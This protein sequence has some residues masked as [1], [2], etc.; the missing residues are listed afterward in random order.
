MKYKKGKYRK[1]QA[2]RKKET[3]KKRYLVNGGILAGIFLAAVIVFSY[4]TNKENNNI[5]ADLGAA[6]R[7]QVSFSYNGYEINALPAYAK[8]MD[9]TAVRGT[10]T[11][12]ANGRLEMK[13]EPHNSKVVS[14]V[15]GVYTL[16]GEE[17]LWSNELK[18]PGESVSL[19]FDNMEILSEERVLKIVLGIK[20]DT[21]QE[22]MYLY[23]RIVDAAGMN[24]EECLSYIRNF[25]E[26]AL[27]KVEDA[28]VGLA[29]EPNEEGDNTTFQHVTIHSDFDHVSWGDLE[30]Q[31]EGSEQYNVMEM[32][33]MYTSAL[34]EYHVRCKGEENDTDVYNVKEFFR[35]RHVEGGDD[36]LLD[37]DRT[38]EQ[39]FDASRVIL[40]D[41]G[42]ILGI[43]GGSVPH[44]VNK[45][46]TIVSFVQA[47]ELWNYNKESGE[48][49]LVFSFSDAENTDDRNLLSQHSLRLLKMDNNG[50]T[51]F[52]VY[53]YMNRGEHEG[54]S[55]VAVYYYEPEKNAVEEKLFIASDKSYERVEEELGG[56]VYY[57]VEQDRL[58]VQADGI[59]YEINAELKQVKELVSG[60]ADSEYVLSPDGH[61]AA[62]KT[63]K[64]AGGEKAAENGGSRRMTVM[65]FASGQERTVE[66]GEGENIV[67]LGF[68][69]EDFVYGV[70]R[71]ADAGRTV[72][73]Q[74]VL[75]MYKIIIE[76]ETGEA[77]K[78]YEQS[79]MYILGAVLDGNLITLDLA[80]KEGESYNS[81]AEDYITN[82]E[83]TG[84]TKIYAEAYVTELKET[85]MRLVFEEA[86]EDRT[87]KL[88]KP[89]QT[90]QKNFRTVDF[91]VDTKVKAKCYVYGY[92]RLRGSYDSAG[93]AIREADTCSGVVVSSWQTY[94]W[95]R[96]NR[97]L[98]YSIEE[99]D[100]EVDQILALLKEGKAPV[101]IMQEISAGR[102]L[103]LT[104]CEAEQVL[105]VVNQNIPVIAMKDAKTAVVITGYGDGTIAYKDG[106]K[107][108]K[109]VSY[110]E[111]EE[112]TKGSGNTYVAYLGTGY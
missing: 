58:Y 28:G 3:K 83:G 100:D 90:L 39:V 33:S 13:L 74:E 72:A 26:N 79:G 38:M 85:Q 65:N 2:K 6:T 54:E 84:E 4:M 57:S 36:Y 70:A 91:A 32:T 98:E 15:Y 1:S 24:T 68:I 106:G 56:L 34:L 46:G 11:P 105:Y 89:K 37:Y 42:L 10:V 27:G 86:T 99:K 75:A 69:N 25:H 43:T 103:D 78:T 23:T 61:L 73:G 50:N 97:D 49:S 71:T 35:V 29:L 111:M 16:D 48:V 12:V 59:F 92:G 52:A 95:Q 9:I 64:E 66:C 87:P 14:L 82:N 7:P 45:D 94:I 63:E 96:G 88:L 108:T 17:K 77:V 104:G 93:E 41:Q 110:K 112:M 40:D 109:T 76:E 81:T 8:E 20:D 47:G 21:T 5:T 80:E 107:G 18:E 22:E 31:I 101:E 55:G 60:L 102:E 53:G 30:P 51:V 44:M 19:T 62:W 67:P